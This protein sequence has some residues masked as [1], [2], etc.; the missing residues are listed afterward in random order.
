L[1][2]LGITLQQLLFITVQIFASKAP[3]DSVEVWAYHATAVNYSNK[4]FSTTPGESIY[5]R[6]YHAR[7]VNYDCKKYY[8]TSL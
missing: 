8:R 2:T 6:A 4:N 7:A 1:Y 3:G 5:I